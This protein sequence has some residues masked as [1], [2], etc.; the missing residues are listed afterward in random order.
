MILEYVNQKL[1]I[2][3]PNQLET[4]DSV[5]VTKSS[6]WTW[7]ENLWMQMFVIL[8]PH[9]LLFSQ[10]LT[11]TNSITSKLQAIKTLIAALKN[12]VCYKT[13]IYFK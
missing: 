3:S 1:N 12:I 6:S 8:L 4:S 7:H 13:Y 2:S 11:L 10:M 9:I 5:V